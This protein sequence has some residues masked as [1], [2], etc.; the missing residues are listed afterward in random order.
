LRQ[1]A[2]AYL[3]AAFLAGDLTGLTLAFFFTLGT[4]AFFFTLG[5]WT[6]RAL[7]FGEVTE[8]E[9]FAS[10]LLFRTTLAPCADLGASDWLEALGFDGETDCRLGASVLVR[11]ASCIRAGGTCAAAAAMASA[12]VIVRALKDGTDCTRDD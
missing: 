8:L 2:A 12:L 11:E 6:F 3:D 7:A 4:L 9:R 10:F 1:G 5:L